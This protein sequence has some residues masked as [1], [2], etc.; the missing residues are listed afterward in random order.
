MTNEK[1]ACD[2]VY[3]HKQRVKL[4]TIVPFPGFLIPTRQF[5]RLIWII[6]DMFCHLTH[7]PLITCEEDGGEHN[8]GQLKRVYCEMHRVYKVL[9]GTIQYENKNVNL[10]NALPR[11]PLIL[12]HFWGSCT[13]KCEWYD[14]STSK[15]LLFT[16]V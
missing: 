4:E 14:W 1:L 10:F 16:A 11:N 6:L 9:N 7:S 2:Q 5:R 13:Q 12:L 15:P 8:D 3:D